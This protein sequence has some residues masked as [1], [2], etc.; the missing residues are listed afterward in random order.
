MDLLTPHA[1]HRHGADGT[2]V[3]RG[4]LPGH[5][6]NVLIVTKGGHR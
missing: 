3:H 2:E 6:V 1:L 5:G 4:R